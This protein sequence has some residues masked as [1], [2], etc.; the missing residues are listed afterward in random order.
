MPLRLLVCLCGMA[1]T[2]CASQ[3][4]ACGEHSSARFGTPRRVTVLGHSLDPLRESFNISADPWRA[5]ALVSPKCSE[6]VRGAEAVEKEIT[7]RYPG[8]QVA[9]IIVW[10]PMLQSDSERAA[11][12]SATIFPENRAA[13]FYDSQQQV[14]CA[15]ARDTFADFVDRARQSLPEDHWL[16]PEFEKRRDSERPQWDLYML[17]AP[18]VHWSGETPQMPTHWIRHLGRDHDRSTSTYWLDSPESGPRQGDLFQAMRDSRCANH[19]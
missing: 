6:C 10:I 3:Q 2:G 4:S 19:N 15:Y 8:S 12:A 16:V 1:L 9:A 7:A 13:Q 5:V 11:Q 14:G 18:G 17:Y